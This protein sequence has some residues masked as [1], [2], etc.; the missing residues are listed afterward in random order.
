MLG[1]HCAAL[2]ECIGSG[3]CLSGPVQP[4]QLVFLLQLAGRTLTLL[5]MLSLLLLKVQSWRDFSVTSYT[6]D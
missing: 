5:D 4:C 3:G 2:R 6:R 1:W